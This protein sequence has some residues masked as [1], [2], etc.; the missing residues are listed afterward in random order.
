MKAKVKLLGI[1]LMDIDIIP[2][3]EIKMIN[4]QFKIEIKE[5]DMNI[6]KD[7]INEDFDYVENQNKNE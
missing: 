7:K 2:N 5:E 6:L 4:F 3:S 1:D